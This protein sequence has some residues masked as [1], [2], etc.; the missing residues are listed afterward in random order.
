MAGELVVFGS[1]GH[2]KVVIEAVLARTPG[3]QIVLLDDNPAAA[4]RT[5]LGISV[6]GTRDWLASNLPGTP[7]AL[8]V[9]DN[10][11]R[12]ALLRWLVDQRREVET[13]IHPSAVVG[14][15]VE[16]GT[17]AFVAAGA[18]LIADARVGDAVIINTGATIDHDCEIGEAAHIA[19]GVRLCGNVRVGAHS[20]IGVGTA[21]RPGITIGADVVV[22]AGS[23]VVT[24]LP[25]A[26]VYAGCPARPI[27]R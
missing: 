4:G 15:T 7:V 12:A 26:G 8:A 27:A 3:R 10:R 20:L 18:I 22:G 21:V 19:P 9:G 11:A 1:G 16:I 2:A 6:S 14:A 5:L 25:D 13:V 23:A 17:G 24:D